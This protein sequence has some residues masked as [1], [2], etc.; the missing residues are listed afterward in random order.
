MTY[1]LAKQLKDAGFPQQVTVEDQTVV[2]SKNVRLHPMSVVDG[3]TEFAYAPTLSELISRVWEY[4]H[5]FRLDYV[6]VTAKWAACTVWG[7]GYEDDWQEGN[8]PEEAVAKL[9]LALNK[10]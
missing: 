1:E 10:K 8:T 9:W 3:E 4:S 7:N 2:F 5:Q 6:Q